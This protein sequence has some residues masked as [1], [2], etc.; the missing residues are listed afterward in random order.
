[1]IA[2]NLKT[3]CRE[4]PRHCPEGLCKHKNSAEL[5][6]TPTLLGQAAQRPGRRAGTKLYDLLALTIR[7]L[8]QTNGMPSVARKGGATGLFLLQF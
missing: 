5:C 3:S 6:I 4:K 8:L 7:W 2:D 1:M